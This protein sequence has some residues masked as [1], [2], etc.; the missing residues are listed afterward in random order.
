MTRN[1]TV[2][3]EHDPASYYA[4]QVISSMRSTLPQ[5]F[6]FIHA[7]SQASYGIVTKHA[8]APS[9]P[10]PDKQVSTTSSLYIVSY[11][12]DLRIYYSNY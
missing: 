10:A 5:L 4:S 7:V 11:V 12:Q 3:R 8:L 1:A 9:W 6:L 2:L